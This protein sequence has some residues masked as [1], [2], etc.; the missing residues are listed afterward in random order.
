MG[1]TG[2]SEGNEFRYETVVKFIDDLIESGSLSPGQKA[3]SLRKVSKARGVSVTTALHAY[4]MLESQGVLE[5]QP[6]SG[7]YVSSIK[8]N[9]PEKPSALAR[10][11][12]VRKVNSGAQVATMFELAGDRSMAPLGCAIPGPDLL[13]SSQLDKFLVRMTRTRGKS[14]NTYSPPRG[15]DGLR[16]AIARR[17]ILWGH[18][19]SA[20]DLMITSGCTEAL[21]LALRALTQPG[22]TIA[23][24]SPTYFG[25]LPMLQSL[26]LSVTEIPTDS[27]DGISIPALE[28]ALQKNTIKACLFSS[29]FN[30][31]LGCLTSEAKKR[32]VLTLLNKHKIPL[33]EDDVYGDI[34]FGKERPRPYCALE[35]AKKVIYCSSFSKTV[36]PGYRIGWLASANYIER[37]STEKYATTLCV[38]TLPQLALSEY[39]NAGAYDN[40]LRGIRKAF[41]SNIIYFS[42]TIAET[43]PPGTRISRPEGGFVLWVELPDGI[44]ARA[45]FNLALKENICFAPGDLFTTSNNYR[46]C[47]RISCGFTWDSSLE[48]A[49]WKLGTL[50]SDITNSS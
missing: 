13:A 12:S 26:R 17:A 10:S 28:T 42:K 19:V 2:Q 41:A 21:H 22:D 8:T 38:P 24:E 39:L 15:E 30:N 47:M 11:T 6:Q 35:N 43:F 40:H 29:A 7:F 45:V 33:I 25:F 49:L 46:S 20:E 31:P 37:L 18:A 34:Y 27:V 50:V 16:S 3:P 36:A 44:N 32:Q 14:A 9:L 48:R 23:I 5:A 4:R 1:N